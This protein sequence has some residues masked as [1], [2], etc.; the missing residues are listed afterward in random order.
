MLIRANT[1]CESKDGA[2]QLRGNQPAEQHFCFRY[3][4]TPCSMIPLLPKPEISSLWFNDCT[5]RFES[6]LVGNA[7]DRFCCDPAHMKCENS[8]SMSPFMRKPVFGV[9]GK[10]RHKLGCTTTEDG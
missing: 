8:H 6:G 9:S 3:I 5:A 1:V 7:E 2:D 10:I 4:G